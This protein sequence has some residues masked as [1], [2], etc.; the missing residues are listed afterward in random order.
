MMEGMMEQRGQGGLSEKKWGEGASHV[1]I[2]VK[3]V[4]GK[5]HGR[6]RGSGGGS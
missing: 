5:E 1:A 6:C 3:N 4:P 2:S